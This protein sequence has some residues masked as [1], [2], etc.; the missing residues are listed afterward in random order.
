MI[1]FPTGRCVSLPFAPPLVFANPDYMLCP[2]RGIKEVL[3]FLIKTGAGGGGGVKWEAAP[4]SGQHG[5]AWDGSQKK[6]CL[7]KEEF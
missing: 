4:P 3:W 2:L 7:Y 1:T 5:G 6:T